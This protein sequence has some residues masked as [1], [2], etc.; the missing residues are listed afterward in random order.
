[1]KS[2][3]KD[4]T[5]IFFLLVVPGAIFLS[6]IIISWCTGNWW[7]MFLFLVT[8]IPA[9]AIGKFVAFIYDNI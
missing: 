1:M 6:P 2:V 4:L 7:Y 3:I 5:W 9:L 8:W